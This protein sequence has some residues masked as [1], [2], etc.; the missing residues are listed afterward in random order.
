MAEILQ[1][2]RVTVKLQKCQFIQ[3]KAKFVGMDILSQG[4]TPARDKA[5]QKITHLGSF[6]DLQGFITFVGFYQEF[7]PPL[8]SLHRPVQE[9]TEKGTT[10]KIHFKGRGNGS[11]GTRMEER[12]QQTL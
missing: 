1:Q 3:T 4:N 5:F 11:T 9:T 12:A 7:P 6:T 8:Q 2:Y 10:A